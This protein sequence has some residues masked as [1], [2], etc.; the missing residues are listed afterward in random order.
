MEQLDSVILREIGTLSRCIHSICDQ[1]YKELKLQKG[2]FIY[3]T[4]ICEHP[5]INLI[6][7]TVL[8]KMDKTSTTKAVQKLDM[9]GYVERKRDVQDQRVIRLYPTAKGLETYD[10]II[11][12]ENRSIAVCLQNFSEDEKRTLTEWIAKMSRNMEAEWKYTKL[13]TGGQED[14]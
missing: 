7:L 4:R 14:D 11:G 8:L 13:H 12:E 1:K 2:Q 6:D 3:L 9:E 10:G 5:G